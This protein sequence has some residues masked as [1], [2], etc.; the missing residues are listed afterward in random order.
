MAWVWGHCAHRT[1]D[2]NNFPP[3]Y[4][5]THTHTHLKFPYIWSTNFSWKTKAPTLIYLTRYVFIS[6][7][8]NMVPKKILSLSSSFTTS[9]KLLCSLHLIPSPSVVFKTISTTSLNPSCP[10]DALIFNPVFFLTPNIF[11]SFLFATSSPAFC[12]FC[13]NLQ[14]LCHSRFHFYHLF[15]RSLHARLHPLHPASTALLCLSCARCFG[16]S[17]PRY[18]STFNSLSFAGSKWHYSTFFSFLFSPGCFPAAP[19]SH[20][21]MITIMSANMHPAWLLLLSLNITFP[22]RKL[23]S[24]L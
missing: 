8:L 1:Q 10:S 21:K 3:A 14:T 5:H 17:T 2:P 15:H 4:V 18:S 22:G 19:Y 7:L 13:H 12:L 23:S 6:V 24:L 11:T 16:W 9:M 20:Y